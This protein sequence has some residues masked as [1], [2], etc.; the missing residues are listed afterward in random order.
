MNVRNLL[1]AGRVE[2]QDLL[3]KGRR[4]CSRI[5]VVRLGRNT[6]LLVNLLGLANDL[7]N[8]RVGDLEYLARDR[9]L[10]SNELLAG[11]V[12]DR[13]QE[14]KEAR[15]DAVLPVLLD[16]SLDNGVREV[17]TVGEELGDDASL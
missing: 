8:N 1:R 15:R 9:L 13:V 16:R 6:P 4:E 5:V 7:S 14:G 17:I 12:V 11:L 2:L 10:L 3:S